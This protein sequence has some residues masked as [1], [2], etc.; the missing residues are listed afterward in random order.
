MLERDVARALALTACFTVSACGS[1]GDVSTPSA[2]AAQSAATKVS[3]SPSS[4]SSAQAATSGGGAKPGAPVPTESVELFEVP[5]GKVVLHPVHHATLYLE[6]PGVTIWVDPWSEGHLDGLPQGDLVLVTDNHPDHLD[7]KAIAQ[8]KKPG[9]TVAGPKVVAAD[10]PELVTMANVEKKTFGSVEVEA[11]AAYNEKR[12]PGPGKLFHDKGR[13][14]GYV[15]TIGGKRLYLSGDTECTAEMK[16]LKDIDV[17]LVCMNLPYTMP[18][19]EAAA[20]VNAFK[21]KVLIPYHYRDSNL[22]DLDAPLA[23]SGVQVK[24]VDFYPKR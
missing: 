22:A 12:G 18:P 3:G 21:P 10:V 7:P 6:A 8:V 20:C 14:N 2:T 4:T 13:G 5:G 19:S 15:L 11:V 16:A 1:S 24:K 23:S 9:A 17:A